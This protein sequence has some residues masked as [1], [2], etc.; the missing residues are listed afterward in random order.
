MRAMVAAL[1]VKVDLL[2]DEHREY[3][4]RHEKTHDKDCAA[5]DRVLEEVQANTGWR[6]DRQAQERI[7]R[8][9]IGSNA[10]VI[11]SLVATLLALLGILTSGP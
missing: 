6:R 9:L 2:M 5:L 8:W 3:V 1:T 4:R 10:L 11:V 7:G